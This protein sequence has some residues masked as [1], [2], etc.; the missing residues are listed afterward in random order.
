MDECNDSDFDFPILRKKNDNEKV[1]RVTSLQPNAS[2]K[3][4]QPLARHIS[5]PTRFNYSMKVKVDT[6]RISDT[7]FGSKMSFRGFIRRMSERRRPTGE[8][9]YMRDRRRAIAAGGNTG[10]NKAPS[11]RLNFMKIDF[12]LLIMSFLKFLIPH[13]SDNIVALSY[14]ASYLRICCAN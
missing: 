7:S 13:V 14:F 1:L 8:S 11:I 2:Q 10:G 5:S 4:K 6:N 3:V 12:I 9:N